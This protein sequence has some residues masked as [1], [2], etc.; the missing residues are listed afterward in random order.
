MS[1]AG[2]SI[3]YTAFLTL[4]LFT[5]THAQDWHFVAFTTPDGQEFISQSGNMIVP[6]IHEAATNYLWPGLQ[7]TDNSGVYQNVLDGRSGGWWFGSGWCCSNPSLSWGGGFSAIEGDVLFFNNTR[8]LNRTEWVS[9]ID[10]NCGE[11]VATNSFPI[12]DKTMN[13]AP[14]A[15]ELYGTWDFGPVIFE[16]VVLIATGS[17]TGFCTE[18][19]WNYNGATNVSITGVQS[20]VQADTVV[21]NIESITLWGPA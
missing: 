3:M 9:V 4:L 1:P 20:T 19:P 11:A 15:A 6:A 18:Y 16:D 17:D 7:T 14:F 21:C 13:D 2:G 10:K 5:Y 12:A 8:D